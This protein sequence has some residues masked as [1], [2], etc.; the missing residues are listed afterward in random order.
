MVNGRRASK[1]MKHKILSEFVPWIAER[2]DAFMKVSADILSQIREIS[3]IEL[4]DPD[5][6]I[7]DNPELVTAWVNTLIEREEK[8]NGND[9][10]ESGTD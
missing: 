3:R 6:L 5:E 8:R 1:E 7:P 10:N 4:V 9:H 2:K